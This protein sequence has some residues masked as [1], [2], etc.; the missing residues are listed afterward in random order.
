MVV[1]VALLAG[2]AIEEGGWRLPVRI[3]LDAGVVI[4]MA[5]LFV[6][7]DRARAELLRLA[8]HDP[9]TGVGNYRALQERLDEEIARHDRTG[10]PF[11][12]LNLDLDEFKEVNED[13]GH[14]AGDRLLQ[15]VAAAIQRTV[16]GA[17]VVF[18]QGGDEFCVIAPESGATDAATLAARID[19]ALRALH[20]GGRPQ[21]ASVG[22]AVCPDD[23][24]RKRDL[25]ARADA[26]QGR[27]KRARRRLTSA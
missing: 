22:W 8:L 21:H 25:L 27:A 20:V 4:C 1:L 26:A 23:G 11:A 10:R 7:A 3:A 9:L 19:A 15:D 14:L 17:D 16:R 13:F 18:R 24:T 2:L 12:V 6:R 5:W